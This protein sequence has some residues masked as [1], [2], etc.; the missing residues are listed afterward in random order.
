MIRFWSQLLTKM[1][2][3]NFERSNQQ[4]V[5]PYYKLFSSQKVTINHILKSFLVT[6]YSYLTVG[7]DLKL[8]SDIRFR[9]AISKLCAFLR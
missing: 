8:H 4:L 5:M 1:L 9:C 2:P 3:R 6:Y 7:A